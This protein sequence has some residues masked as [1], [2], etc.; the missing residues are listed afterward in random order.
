MTRSK[1]SHGD[2]SIRQRGPTIWQLRWRAN[3]KPQSATFRGSRSE[4]NAELRRLLR[5]RDEGANLAGGN[6]TLAT[7]LKGWLD[8][9]TELSPKTR[10]R[11][12]QLVAHQVTPHLGRI[13]V[14]DLRPANVAEWHAIL[15]RSGGVHGGSLSPR[16]V[17]H[18]HRVLH[19]ALER[20]LVLEIVGT[21]VRYVTA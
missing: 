14:S 7:Y 19:R 17:T 12:R 2:G 11:Y 6:V 5:L 3:G 20:A 10:E 18:A 8:N 21:N 4:A 13:R 15:L 9:D 1:R 16:T